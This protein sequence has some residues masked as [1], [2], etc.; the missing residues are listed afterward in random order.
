MSIDLFDCFILDPRS[1]RLKGLPIIFM[2]LTFK[3]FSFRV[4]IKPYNTLHIFG[5]FTSLYLAH[6]KELSS[7]FATHYSRHLFSFSIK[8]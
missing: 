4:F 5:F 1:I 3:E 8:I 2:I 7:F 6:H